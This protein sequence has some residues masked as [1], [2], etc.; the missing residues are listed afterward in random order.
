MTKQQILQQIISASNIRAIVAVSPFGGEGAIVAPFCKDNTNTV[1]NNLTTQAYTVTVLDV[2][3]DKSE[4]RN[5]QVVV[6][7]ENTASETAY[8]AQ[9]TSAATVHG[10]PDGVRAAVANYAENTVGIKN[11]SIKEYDA[12]QQYA[13]VECWI[14]TAT[15]CSLKKY[16]VFKS[17]AALTHREITA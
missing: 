12:A 15:N 6:V 14:D 1:V 2:S 10:V 16:R 9:N 8:Y 17:G 7:G 5:I 13:V 4:R 11:Y 3:G